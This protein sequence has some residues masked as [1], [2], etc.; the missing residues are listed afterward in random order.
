MSREEIEERAEKL[1]LKTE[2]KIEKA[3]IKEAKDKELAREQ[4]LDAEATD[5]AFGMSPSD[6]ERQRAE[7]EKGAT[8]QAEQ[9][10]MDRIDKILDKAEKKS[11]K[12]DSMYS[13]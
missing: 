7:F 12:L 2:E 11:A 13:E 3:F 1:S 8:E 5:I 10:C 4:A 6:A 9:E